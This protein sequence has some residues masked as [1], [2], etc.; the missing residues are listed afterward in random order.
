MN[1]QITCLLQCHFFHNGCYVNTAVDRSSKTRLQQWSLQSK[2]FKRSILLLADWSR[3]LLEHWFSK[4]YCCR[5]L[6]VIFCPNPAI[7]NVFDAAMYVGLCV[8]MMQLEKL[9]TDL[10]KFGVFSKIVLACWLGQSPLGGGQCC[11]PWGDPGVV[12]RPLGAYSHVGQ[13]PLGGTSLTT[14]A[15]RFVGRSLRRGGYVLWDAAPRLRRSSPSCQVKWGRAGLLKV[16]G[17]G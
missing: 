15:S 10:D 14:T 3:W 13:S 12:D 11:V 17:M 16:V 7:R 1:S 2:G 4:S 6:L 8:R 5:A 9:W